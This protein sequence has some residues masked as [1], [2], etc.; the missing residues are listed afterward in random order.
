VSKIARVEKQHVQIIFGISCK[1]LAKNYIHKEKKF[2][3]IFVDSFF[4]R[5]VTEP[6]RKIETNDI[7]KN[8]FN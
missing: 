2:V 5:R 3:L 4:Q 7:S 1:F 8:V 6:F